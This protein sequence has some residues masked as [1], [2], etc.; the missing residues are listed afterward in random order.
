MFN[1]NETGLFWKKITD[2][3]YNAKEKNMPG[4]KAYIP[5]WWKSC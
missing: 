5:T 4:F 2:Q 3:S 1:A